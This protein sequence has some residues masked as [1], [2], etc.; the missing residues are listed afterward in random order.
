MYCSKTISSNLA[1]TLNCMLILNINCPVS[2]KAFHNFSDKRNNQKQTFDCSSCAAFLSTCSIFPHSPSLML[3]FIKCCSISYRDFGA[4][5]DVA[6]KNTDFCLET[7]L[8]MQCSQTLYSYLP[9]NLE[10]QE[11]RAMEAFICRCNYIN[12]IV[13]STMYANAFKKCR[14]LYSSNFVTDRWFQCEA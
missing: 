5:Y 2:V 8:N 13:N 11:K 1:F 7:S 9:S 12:F 3:A 10:Q 6:F 4:L 14:K